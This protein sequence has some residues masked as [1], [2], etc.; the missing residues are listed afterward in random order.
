MLPAPLANILVPDAAVSP[1]EAFQTIARPINSGLPFTL[2]LSDDFEAMLV[3]PTGLARQWI[4][5]DP[6]G[7]IASSSDEQQPHDSAVP[8]ASFVGRAPLRLLVR[9]QGRSLASLPLNAGVMRY[10]SD[11]GAATQGVTLAVV[12]LSWTVCAGSVRGA[13]DFGS[14]IELAWRVVDRA[15]DTFGPPVVSRRVLQRRPPL[16]RIESVLGLAISRRI[17]IEAKALRRR[18]S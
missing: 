3:L 2:T 9:R 11:S 12:P 13:G 1:P 14:R 15:I 16:E 8:P 10:V 6:G 7:V 4:E 17:L 5:A 18:F